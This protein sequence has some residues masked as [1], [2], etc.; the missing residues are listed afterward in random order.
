MPSRTRTAA[1]LLAFTGLTLGA[2]VATAHAADPVPVTAA[3]PVVSDQT[4]GVGEDTILIPETEGVT[5]SF[6][7]DGDRLIFPEGVELP[8]VIAALLTD[9]GFED[10]FEVWPD[11]LTLTLDVTADEG[12]VLAPGSAETVEVTLDSTGCAPVEQPSVV[13]ESTECESVTLTNPSDAEVTVMLE[14]WESW[15]PTSSVEETLAPGATETLTVVE[16]NYDWFAL[17]SR[18]AS[19]FFLGEPDDGDFEEGMSSTTLAK[20]SLEDVT[21]DL[22]RALGGR[23]AQADDYTPTAEDLEELRQIGLL[24]D[25]LESGAYF[26]GT[27]MVQV[28]SCDDATSEPTPPVTPVDVDGTPGTADPADEAPRVPAVVQTDGGS[29]D[30]SPVGGLVLVGGLLLGAGAVVRRVVRG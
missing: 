4:C 22:P 14:D 26:F 1:T 2:P 6:T 9:G 17:D 21:T 25:G 18:A 3:T 10:P 12:Y 29:L 30:R 24:I 5:Y 16:G 28:E 15:E 8:G 23:A 27:G 11:E 7:A 19:S 13:V 20:K